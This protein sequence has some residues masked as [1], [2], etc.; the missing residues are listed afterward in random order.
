MAGTQNVPTSL[1]S[2]PRCDICGCA[3][4]GKDIGRTNVWCKRCIA[5]A[6]PFVNIEGEGDFRRALHEYREGLGSRAAE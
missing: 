6:L 2:C 5:G 4:R 1:G 3:V